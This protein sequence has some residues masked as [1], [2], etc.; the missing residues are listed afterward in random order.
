MALVPCRQLGWAMPQQCP[1]TG[2]TVTC[3]Q[4]SVLRGAKVS[5]THLDEGLPSHSTAISAALE[6]GEGPP[7]ACCGAGGSV[8]PPVSPLPSIL[9]G[10]PSWPAPH[11]RRC[12]GSET[13]AAGS[14]GHGVSLTTGTRG[15]LERAG[16]PGCWSGTESEAL[17]V[18]TLVTQQACCS[19]SPWLCT[20]PQ[21]SSSSLLPAQPWVPQPQGSRS[22][23]L[24]ERGRSVCLELSSP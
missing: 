18:V 14:K 7:V 16:G 6:A 13:G 22:K 12:P 21:L 20:C 4:F 8:H 15:C 11:R 3:H 17:D 23:L 1:G 24:P 9:M 5:W 19:S 2:H 10:L